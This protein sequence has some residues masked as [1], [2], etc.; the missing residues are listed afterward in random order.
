MYKFSLSTSR[1]NYGI[2]HSWQQQLTLLPFCTFCLTPLS[3]K[4]TYGKEG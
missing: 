3:G 2:I 1:K 4:G